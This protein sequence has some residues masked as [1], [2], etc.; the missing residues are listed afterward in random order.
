MAPAATAAAVVL[1]V[2]E[3][4]LLMVLLGELVSVADVA[5]EASSVS[6]G[7]SSPSEPPAELSLIFSD[8]SSD[9]LPLS[10]ANLALLKRMRLTTSTLSSTLRA[11]AATAA[12][13]SRPIRRT[14]NWSP[15]TPIGVTLKTEVI[16]TLE[17][18]VE[19]AFYTISAWKGGHTQ[20]TISLLSI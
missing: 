4:D 11:A 15:F 2:R 8:R 10:S 1:R 7:P 5:D 6:S 14:G 17:G 16:S 9:I 20:Q 3:R 18:S 13:V 12:A 19:L